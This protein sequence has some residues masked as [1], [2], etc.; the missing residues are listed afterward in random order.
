MVLHGG[1]LVNAVEVD[2]MDRMVFVYRKVLGF[3]IDLTRA[4]VNDPGRRTVLPAS[5]QEAQVRKSIDLKI[6]V[7]LLHAPGVADFPGEIEDHLSIG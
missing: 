5:Q 7:R 6:P 1:V 3:A 4:G 2:R